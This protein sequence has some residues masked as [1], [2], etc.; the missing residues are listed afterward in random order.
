[1]NNDNIIIKET[2]IVRSSSLIKSITLILSFSVLTAVG[3]WIE[4]PTQPVPFTL[5]T[6]FVLLSGAILGYRY[7]FY[8]QVIYLIMGV[9]GI[10]VFAGFSSGILKLFGPTGGYLLSFPIAAFITGYLVNKK[11]SYLWVMFSVASGMALVFLLGTLYLNIVYFKNIFKAISY[12]FVIFSWWD[13]LK[14]L[15]VTSIYKVFNNCFR[16]EK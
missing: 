3:A 5:Q 13:A 8:S 1:M 9:I 6:F 11:D 10:P 14:I 7:G 4:I 15:A 16:L 2:I 12:G